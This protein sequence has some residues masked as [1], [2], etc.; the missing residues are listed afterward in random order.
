MED[1]L[2][3]L[4]GILFVEGPD[5]AAAN[6]ADAGNLVAENSEAGIVPPRIAYALQ[7][8]LKPEAGKLPQ[9]RPGKKPIPE[10]CRV[11]DQQVFV[12]L[13]PGLPTIVCPRKQWNK[14]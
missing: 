2:D 8:G 7:L 6:T 4:A 9:P 12:T 13:H 1:G 10:L 5:P 11:L 14:T 3:P